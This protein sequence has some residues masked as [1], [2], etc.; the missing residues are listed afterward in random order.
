MAGVIGVLGG[1]GPLATIDF[2]Q[3]V[4]EQTPATTDQEHLPMLVYSLPQIPD[5]LEHLK[6]TG[7]SPLPAM[8][9]ALTLLARAGVEVVAIPCNTAHY[10]YD[11]MVRETG[12]RI[13]H[14]ADA[15]CDELDAPAPNGAPVGLLATFATTQAGFYQER[16][17][18]RG[19][20]CVVNTP[21]EFETLVT[22]AIYGIKR[23]EV[24]R[25]GRLLEEAAHRLF[26]R[27]AAKLVLACTEI[28][29]ALQHIGSPVL[30]RSIDA[31]RALARGCVRYWESARLNTS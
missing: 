21:S 30:A 22:P 27:G 6:G 11:D 25:S 7:A 14:I 9:E 18:V 1:M 5:R 28:P 2:M 24:D 4:Y 3:K 13:L 29:V 20:R 17:R 16:L 12:L 19:H 10:W 31:T 26:D 23:G 15:A 8:L